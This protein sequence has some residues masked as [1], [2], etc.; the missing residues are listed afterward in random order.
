MKLED[1]DSFHEMDEEIFSDDPVEED[2]FRKRVGCDGF[3]ALTQEG[4]IVGNLIVAPY[5]NDEGHLGRIGVAKKYQ[6]KGLGSMLMD[7][8]IDWFQK[9]D[10]VLNVHLYTQDFNK[11]AQALYKKYGFVRS[12][13]TWHYFV[14]F[15]SLQPKNKYSCQEIKEE[16]I[17]IVGSKFPSLPAEQIRRFLSYEEFLVLTLKDQ[18]GS[19]QGACRFTPSFPGCF[20]FEMT[21]TECF[22]DF[23]SGM[24]EFSLPEYNYVRATFTNLPELAKLCEKR[25]YRLHHRL[26]KMLLDLNRTKY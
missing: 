25:N 15:D 11:S 21:T 2:F 5:G 26:S 23:I 24:K 17:D 16:E 6:N 19:I 10:C 18:N 14:P 1:W 22:D 9:Q 8:A 12:G 3:F 20:S 13:T 7:Y 4:Q